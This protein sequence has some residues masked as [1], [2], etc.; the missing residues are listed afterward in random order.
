MPVRRYDASMNRIHNNKLS[1]SE[2]TNE[3]KSPAIFSELREEMSVDELL[4][5]QSAIT[6]QTVIGEG[7][8]KTSELILL[9]FLIH[10]LGE[11][12]IVYRATLSSWKDY[13]CDIVAIKGNRS[14]H[15]A[16]MKCSN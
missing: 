2:L 9:D 12:G 10:K 1:F 5:P 3:P 4:V 14:L 11:F 16:L 13:D 15:R 7:N 6:I 8:V